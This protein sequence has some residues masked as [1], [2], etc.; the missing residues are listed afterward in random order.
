VKPLEQEKTLKF[1]VQYGNLKSTMAF[2]NYFKNGESL[3]NSMSRGILIFILFLFVAFVCNAQTSIKYDSI[4]PYS[5]G[6]AAVKLNSKWGYIDENKKLVIPIQYKYADPFSEGI[7]SVYLNKFGCIDKTGKV[8]IAFQYD[9]I[10]KFR[11]GLA[12]V[13]QVQNEKLKWGYIDKTGKEVIPLKYDLVSFNFNEG[14]A[15]VL[16][17]GKYGYIDKTGREIITIQYDVA[18]DF[19]FGYAF[20][21]SGNEWK[22]INKNGEELSFSTFGD[23]LE[24]IRVKVNGKIGYVDNAFKFITPIKYDVADAI[25][26]DNAVT[27][28]G[29]KFGIVGK[30]GEITAPKYDKVY[31]SSEGIRIV[32]QDNK[33]GYINEMGKEIVPIKYDAAGAFHE[34]LARVGIDNEYTYHGITYGYIDNTGKE[35]TPIKYDEA[36]DFS[37]GLARVGIYHESEVTFGGYFTDAYISYGYID[38]VGKEVIP[39]KY[40]FIEDFKN[41]LAKVKLGNEEFYIDKNGN[42]T[43]KK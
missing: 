41:G 19:S 40:D 11:E 4:A 9:G 13:Q 32:E 22:I 35:L 42:K 23:K 39:L 16:L 7:A 2:G 1:M 33:S 20:V 30:N 34:G 17:D 36:Y 21:K 14:L 37:N 18:K 26:N 29:D 10:G 38:K 6:L 8:V 15:A 5:E 31:A 3:K 28:I 27:K 24:P 43:D 12:W 25:K